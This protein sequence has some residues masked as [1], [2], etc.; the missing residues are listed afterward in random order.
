MHHPTEQSRKRYA[1]SP[2]S[3]S[4][5]LY[6]P[7]RLSA[8][9]PLLLVLLLATC[10]PADEVTEPPA[11]PEPD[12]EAEPAPDPETEPITSREELRKLM[13]GE[14]EWVEELLQ[15]MSL[16]E[17]V[18]QM[19]M[20]PAYGHY[21]SADTRQ[22]EQM[23]EWVED[24]G[25][26][27]LIFFQGDVSEQALL[28]EE[29]Q[30]RS[31][32]PLLI[33]SDF[34]RGPA[35]RIRRSTFFPT[36]MALGA[37]RDQTLAYRM[38]RAI[39]LESRAMGIHQNYAPVVDVN[40]N[41]QNPVIN[42]R[43]FGE[44]PSLV[45]ELGEAYMRGLQDYGMLATGKHFP[46]HGDTD[47][48]SHV[49]LPVVPF[50]RARLDSIELQPFNRLIDQ[51]VMSIMS[52]HI[53]IPEL[54]GGEP[55]PSTLSRS[56]MHDLLRR[57]M[58][59]PG[60]IVTD[61]MGMHGISGNYANSEAAVQ[62]VQAGV[63]VL[64]MPPDVPGAIEAVTAAVELE[65]IPEEQINRSVRRI[66]ATKEWA[67]LHHGN[68]LDLNKVRQRVASKRSENLA[69]EIAERSAT[70][71]RN[72]FHR[73]P[74][75]PAGNKDI[76]LVRITNQPG[77]QTTVHRPGTFRPT[78]DT[79]AHFERTFRRDYPNVQTAV[80]D[81]R[82]NREEIDELIEDAREAD[83]VIG[84]SYIAAR[85]GDYYFGLPDDMQ[86]ALQELSAL[87]QH[88][89]IV[90][91]GDPYFISSV[92]EVDAY[93]A[94]YMATD[95]TVETAVQTL[96]GEN[97][98]Q[99]RLPVTIPGFA[100]YGTGLG[101]PDPGEQVVTGAKRLLEQVPEELA[102]KRLGMI[103]NHSAR[104]GEEH[105]VDHL[106][107]HPE[108][109]VSALFGPEHGIRGDAAAGETIAGG[110]DPQTGLPVHSLYGEHRRPTDEML[111]DVDALVFDIQDIGARFY[112]YIS[113][114][115]LAMQAAA[116]QDIPYYVLDRPNPLGGERVEG[117]LLEEQH[118]SFVGQYPI[119]VTH[120][121]TVGE[122]A[123]MIRGEN[124]L[125]GLE[126]LDLEVIEMDG[127]DRSRQWTDTRLDWTPP[128]PNIPDFGTALIY[129]GACFFEA[130]TASEGRGTHQP[131]RKLGAPWTDG[132]QLAEELNDRDIPGLRFQAV[133]FTPESIEGMAVNPKFEDETVQGIR[134]HILDP[135][136][137]E[138][139]LAGL[140]VLEAFYRQAPEDQRQDF[141]DAP[142]M[143][144]LAGT[145]RMQQMIEDGYSPEE[146]AE[147][148]QAD[149]QAFINQR[150]P[151]LL[152]R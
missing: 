111:E 86:D 129:P 134:Y 63:D 126:E 67:G 87:P 100:E 136:K 6:V 55:V 68:E 49:D 81:R 32:V 46:G 106:T 76:L 4:L 85:S 29:M 61:A 124:M 112:T 143:D 104:V 72:H 60:L 40:N 97:E 84:H 148:W 31:E 119:P 9:L 36:A 94:M 39:A 66:L 118:T 152:Y 44:E 69:T 11:P 147:S 120:G 41:P 10:R 92:P 113:T 128:S 74:I 65:E 24:Y 133:E 27:G 127:W 73:I 150:M 144:H 17:K 21:I 33:S 52:A 80:L 107:E 53:A 91:F 43:S 35:M 78:E 110:E 108:L 64:L 45:G 122:L 105:L 70:L 123:R 79:G 15:Q 30:Q 116:E 42:T 16:E 47:V 82:S 138:P 58:D 101:F 137:V 141:F 56:I 145:R 71:V 131:F 54:T 7:R 18:A 23:I 117:F 89:A 57:E 98:P 8:L 2:Y 28:I 142:R 139:V 26:G 22:Y 149:V 62:A 3:W 96:L 121:M 114:M 132:E 38:G 50:N 34:E 59:Y 20:P 48:D 130:T 12:P 135:D 125:E 88:L 90:S 115:G 5:F 1:H 13:D 151:Y 109:Q 51:G 99:G 95:A 25:I 75:D 14:T 19:I 103:T 140:H 77:Q 37:A 146:I 102:G 83:M 93:L